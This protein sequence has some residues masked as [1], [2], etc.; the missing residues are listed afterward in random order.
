[1][2]STQRNQDSP[3]HGLVTKTYIVAK[4]PL[5]FGD[6]SRG[7]GEL[8]PEASSW[9]PRLVEAYI[10]QGYLE[11]VVLVTD[12]DR[13]RATEQWEQEEA[14]RAEVAEQRAKE[15]AAATEQ[16]ERRQQPAAPVYVQA[17][18][19]VNCRVVNHFEE[20]HDSRHIFV[21]ANCGQRQSVLQSRNGT[22]TYSE[23]S[24][25]RPSMWQ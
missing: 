6:H 3:I 18:V 19:C 7:P 16:Q 9:L 13:Q 20:R 21:C 14:A 2:T 1:V 4:R 25:Y 5:R 8:V 11:E 22:L 15:A 10:A 17:E 23:A 12:A 24:N